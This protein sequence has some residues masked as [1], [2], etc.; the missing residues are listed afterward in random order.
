MAAVVERVLGIFHSLFP[1]FFIVGVK[2][3]VVHLLVVPSNDLAHFCAAN[4]CP[5]DVNAHDAE[6]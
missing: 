3:G 6:A 1:E 4:I 5:C 2:D